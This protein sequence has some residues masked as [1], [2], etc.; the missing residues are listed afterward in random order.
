MTRKSRRCWSKSIG[1]PGRRVRLYEARPGGSIM[2]SVFA[3]GK[4]ARRSLGHRDKEKAIRQGYELL[5]ALLA[6]EHAL[7]EE[8]LTLGMVAELYKQSPAFATKK[9]RTRKADTRTLERVVMFLG[10]ARNVETLSESDVQRFVLARRQGVGSLLRVQ[11]GKVV[12]DQA[13]ASDLVILMTALNWATRERTK[14]GRRLLKENPLHGVRLP[15]EK[16]PKRPV[17]LHDVYLRLL[18]VADQVHPLLKLA[19]IV[20]E[21]TGRR[22]SAW[23]NLRW[24]DVDFQAGM[25]RWRAE[26]DKTGF[27]QIVPMTEPVKEALAAARRAQGAIGN[28]PV[29]RAPKDPQKPCS[30]HLFDSWLRKAYELLTDIPRERWTLWHSIRR[31]WATERKGYPVR[32]VMEAG[33][34]K[35]EETLLRSYQQPDAETVRQVVLHPTQRIVSR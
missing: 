27:E 25:I 12:R 33:G 5:Q 23:C 31:K 7:D 20:A 30:R 8:S 26:T 15:R 4:E 10:R 1:E 34:W 11:P 35:N 22:I 2:R 6:N 13:I 21:G 14:D 28:T 17:M 32:D 16:N 18:A 24:D 29:F 19:L 9:A 3:N